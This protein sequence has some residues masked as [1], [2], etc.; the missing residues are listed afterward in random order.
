MDEQAFLHRGIMTTESSE[1]ESARGLRTL[2]NTALL[3]LIVEELSP[4]SIARIWN[5]HL[6]RE[7]KE[8]LSLDAQPKT[9]VLSGFT[10]SRRTFREAAFRGPK[11]LLLTLSATG[12]LKE[13][14]DTTTSPM[15]EPVQVAPKPA[16]IKASRPLSP[17]EQR[18]LVSKGGKTGYQP[19]QEVQEEL[20]PEMAR[21]LA[22][23][24]DEAHASIRVQQNFIQW[25]C[26]QADTLLMEH[27]KNEGE[28]LWANPIRVMVFP[29]DPTKKATFVLSST[30]PLLKN[31]PGSPNVKHDFRANE[32][33]VTHAHP[34]AFK[35][36][37]GLKVIRSKTH[38]KGSHE[39]YVKALNYMN[40]MYFKG[41]FVVDGLE[42]AKTAPPRFFQVR[43]DRA[44]RIS[45]QDFHDIQARQAAGKPL[46]EE[47]KPSRDEMLASLTRKPN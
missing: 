6:A 21:Q 11:G 3:D 25:V 10:D 47:G 29:E 20:D 19:S 4:A 18:M 24:A 16:P 33:P 8:T 35:Q 23:A 15:I 28:A 44:V 37:D 26:I 22:L 31:E 2:G 43:G 17:L 38:R 34:E 40:G 1:R 46:I 42:D 12:E 5:R 32:V 41:Y 27:Q 7:A 36:V 14:G 13:I 45:E 9:R 30:A 39:Y